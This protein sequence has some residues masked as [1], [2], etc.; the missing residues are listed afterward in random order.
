MSV[1]LP[2]MLYSDGIKKAKQ[3]EFKGYNHNLYAK[4]GE[5]WDMK[6]LTSDLYPLLSPRLPRYVVE[7]LEKPN[8]FYAKDGMYW[9]DGTGFYA[10]GEKKGDVADSRKQFTSIGAYVIILP[11]KKWYNRLTGEFGDMETSWSGSVKIQDGTYAGESAEANTIYAAGA[12]WADTFQVGDAV[13]ISGCTTHESNNQTIIIREI[14]GD[15]LRFY[16]NSFTINAGGDTESLAIAREMPELDFICENENRLWGCK[17][18]TVYASKLG[19]PFNW[20]VFDGLS[21]DSFAVDVGSAG[22]FTGCCSY[23]GYPCIFK[24]EHIYKVYGDKPRNY[25]VMGSASLGVEKGSHQ[26]LAIAGETLYYLS[27]AGVTAYN[28]GIPRSVADAFGGVRYHSAVGGSD[29]VKYYVSMAD[30]ENRFHLFVYD[31]RYGLWH[32]EDALEA[33]GFGWNGALYF[34]SAAGPL[35]CGG[36]ARTV[37]EGAVSE[38]AVDS[39]AEFA[40]FTQ[41]SPDKKGAGKLQ[42]RVEL[43]AGAALAVDIQFDSDGVWRRV[44]AL[45]ATQKRSFLL[46]IVPRRCDHCRLRLT[47]AGKIAAARFR[48][49]CAGLMRVARERGWRIALYEIGAEFLL[50]V[51]L[52]AGLY[53]YAAW[54]YLAC[55]AF[56]LGDFAAI[57]GALAVGFRRMSAIGAG[58]FVAFTGVVFRNAT[59]ANTDIVTGTFLLIGLV[60][61]ATGARRNRP[62]WFLLAGAGFGLFVGVISDAISPG[63]GGGMTAGLA[64]LGA[65][66]GL[67]A[68]YVLSQNLLGCLLCSLAALCLIDLVRVSWNLIQGSAALAA[69]LR[70]AVPE[71]FWS[72]VFVF[73]VYGIFRWVF[74]RVPERTHF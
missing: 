4:D 70:V 3:T 39:M 22:D 66:A 57:S 35:W 18:D 59:V 17:G 23:L 67:L 6:N 68:Q 31:T 21:T 45:S 41:G 26:S 63:T 60:F 64:L 5:L 2:Q 20:N 11:D 48:E 42:L 72:L 55:A 58:L 53:G 46:P 61:L 65:G 36:G 24:E 15:N 51:V 71:I 7:T 74:R 62:G 1:G 12:N 56:T 50:R 28:G 25:Q 30:G 32:R 29:G 54:R 9:V 27:R 47:G 44:D 13:A 37:P 34:L 33:V 8:G 52:Y 16:E 49:G 10:D 14:D 69:L 73:P 38:G 19:D 40:D 43:E